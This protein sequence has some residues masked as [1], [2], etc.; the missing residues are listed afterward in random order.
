MLFISQY[1]Q[2]EKVCCRQDT[3]FPEVHHE[4]GFILQF[5]NRNYQ[6]YQPA[7]DVVGLGCWSQLHFLSLYFTVQNIDLICSGYLLGYFPF[8]HNNE[9]PCNCVTWCRSS[10]SWMKTL[11]AAIAVPKRMLQ[12][13]WNSCYGLWIRQ[14]YYLL[15][16]K[17]KH[18]TSWELSI[19]K[20]SLTEPPA[21]IMHCCPIDVT[22]IHSTWLPFMQASPSKHLLPFKV[23]AVI[24][25]L[26][27]TNSKQPSLFMWKINWFYLQMQGNHMCNWAN[28]TFCSPYVPVQLYS[29]DIFFPSLKLE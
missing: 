2:K 11:M 4:I 24:R 7:D 12:N 5:A 17:A 15:S 13:N 23:S 21:L 20:D 3:S 8:K 26:P 18:F 29:E 1:C 16:N 6:Y 27:S 22:A 9:W 25:K 19:F 14:L 10:Q 28:K